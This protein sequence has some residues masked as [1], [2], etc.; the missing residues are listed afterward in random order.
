VATVALVR[1]GR[2]AYLAGGVD[3]LN[4]IRPMY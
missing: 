4:T 1:A 2:V 3:G